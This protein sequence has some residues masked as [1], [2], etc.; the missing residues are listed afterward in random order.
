MYYGKRLDEKIAEGLSPFK[1]HTSDGITTDLQEA[2]Y[3]V[4]SVKIDGDQI[5]IEMIDQKTGKVWDKANL[6]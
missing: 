1:F 5:S 2:M 4:V 3:Y 6:N